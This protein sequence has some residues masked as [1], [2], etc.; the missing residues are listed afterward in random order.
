LWLL[1]AVAVVVVLVAEGVL[2]AIA[3]LWWVN[4]LVL[5]A[6]RNQDCL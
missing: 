2:V 5:I 3:H 6:L 1:A 4:Y